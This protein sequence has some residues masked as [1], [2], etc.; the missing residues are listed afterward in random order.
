MKLK[1]HVSSLNKKVI[2]NFSYCGYTNNLIN[3]FEKFANVEITNLQNSDVVIILA[4][5]LGMDFEVDT[6]TIDLIVK[7]KKPIVVIDYTEYGSRSLKIRNRE[8]NIYGYKIEY[9]DLINS[10][11][12]NC[13]HNFLLNN[14]Q[15]ICCYFKRELSSIV[16]LNDVPFPVFPVEFVSEDYNMIN[17]IPDSMD[18]YLNR[19][20]IYNF[21]WGLS[22][23]CRLH[24]HGAMLLNFEKFSC[25][26]ISSRAQYEYKIKNKDSRSIT[27][28]NTDWYERFN[29]H[30]INFNSRMV[31]DLYGAGQKCFRNV[32]CTKNSLSVK[33]DPSKLLHT[34][35]WIDGENCIHL[36]V[37]D[38]LTLDIDRSIDVLLSYRHEK[39]CELYKMY[40]NSIE[41]N[42]KYSLTNYVKNHIIYNIQ[43]TI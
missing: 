22:N 30:D 36:P 29:L 27:L 24:L 40:L 13:I 42:M 34:Y 32:E 1:I 8:Y 38:D 41:T 35:E 23:M 39:Q 31:I 18:E 12:G 17:L 4:T 3:S 7:L 21:I 11:E 2:G 5:Y 20:C 43:C 15:N 28:I 6:E 33:Q 19:N 37:T 25:D 14:N 16:N 26:L 9:E 10:K